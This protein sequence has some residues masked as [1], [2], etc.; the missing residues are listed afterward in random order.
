MIF[1]YRVHKMKSG[2]PSRQRGALTMLSAVLILILLTEMVLYAAQVGVFEQRK[3]GNELRQ[4]Q[5]FH[6]AEVGI[7]RGQEYLLAYVL[8]LT[9]TNDTRGWMSTTHMSAGGSGRWGC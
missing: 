1:N 9:S 6:A 2:L 4:K 3:S 7:Q 5:A 8:D